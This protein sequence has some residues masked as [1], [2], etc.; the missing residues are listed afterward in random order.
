M[1]LK[2][3]ELASFKF[4]QNQFFIFVE[5]IKLQNLTKIKFNSFTY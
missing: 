2:S 3:E 5:E 1:C 4:K